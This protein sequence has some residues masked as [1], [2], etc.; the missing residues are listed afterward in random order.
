V[1][2]G[3]LVEIGEN[4]DSCSNIPYQDERIVS[5]IYSSSSIKTS[6]YSGPGITNNPS[7]V[8]PLTLCRQTEDRVLNGQYVNK[9]RIIYEP[10]INPT[11]YGIQSVG[12][13]STAIF[14]Q[15]V[16][17]FFDSEKENTTGV[18]KNTIYIISQNSVVS[19][20]ATAVVSSAG[21]IS[22]IIINDGGF[23][24]DSDPQV[25]VSSPIGLGNTYRAEL[26][27]SVTSGIVTS[28]V[29]TSPGVGYTYTN[30][31]E[32]LIEVP[33]LKIE[34]NLITSYEGDFGTIIGI[35]TTSVGVS[36]GLIFDLLIPENSYLRD[37]DIVGSAITVSQ[38]NSGYYFTAYNTNIGNGVTSLYTDGSILGIGT[39][40]LDNV[41]E[42]SSVSIAQT[43]AP[44]YGT[45]YVAQVTVSISDYNSLTG[46][47][48]SSYFGEYSWGKVL[49]GDRANPK[50]FDSYTLNGVGGITTSLVVTRK[51]PLKYL[52]YL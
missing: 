27:S 24:Y 12:L 14:V 40:Y 2:E 7:C 36:T 33:S 29:V 26:V 13:A 3:D 5:E 35:K 4:R 44:G 28:I 30:P 6:T 49:L 10:L 38:L 34:Q 11:T 45:T 1:K 37:T 41:Y 32:V 21:T 16:K 43:G 51:N 47:G 8:R 46:T 31:P 23:G 52:N 9:D 42:V 22:S 39:Q 50:E 25:T 48:Y 15:S 19:A 17:T 20:S 18:A